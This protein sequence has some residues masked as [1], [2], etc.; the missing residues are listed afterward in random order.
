MRVLSRFRPLVVLFAVT[1]F[2]CANVSPNGEHEAGSDGVD[3]HSADSS[4]SEEPSDLSATDTPAADTVSESDRHLEVADSPPEDTE[5][6]AE[7]TDTAGDDSQISDT[8]SETEPDESLDRAPD[9][10][11]DREVAS[12]SIDRGD[13]D[14]DV[15]VGTYESEVAEDIVVEDKIAPV[16][17]VDF[18]MGA[19]LT[20]ASRITV[21]GR[22]QDPSGISSLTIG[23]V[24]A[25]SD[26][27]FATWHA[28]LELAV[29]D[30]DFLVTTSDSLGNS[31]E[32]AAAVAI[33]RRRAIPMVLD[34][35]AVDDEERFAYTTD[36]VRNVLLRGDLE[37][38]TF[39]TLNPSKPIGSV[40]GLAFARHD[41]S[42][43]LFILNM[44]ELLAVDL[45]SLE[46]VT[47]DLDS[48]GITVSQPF[49]LDVSDDGE[50]A[51][52]GWNQTSGGYSVERIELSTMTRTTIRTAAGYVS[53]L[54]TDSTGNLYLIDNDTVDARLINATPRGGFS[55]LAKY[56]DDLGPFPGTPGGIEVEYGDGAI[57]VGGNGGLVRV[58][59]SSSD[60]DVLL[61]DVEPPN[62][63]LH[64]YEAIRSFGG[65]D[66]VVEPVEAAIWRLGSDD[67]QPAVH[68]FLGS[69]PHLRLPRGLVPVESAGSEVFVGDV[70]GN[71]YRIDFN[72]GVRTVISGIG[73][74]FGR[75]FFGLESL[76]VSGTGL[77]VLDRDGL[78]LLGTEHGERVAISDENVGE[79]PAFSTPSDLLMLDE[80]NAVVLDGDRVLTVALA[81]GNRE[82]LAD[83]ASSWTVA[84]SRSEGMVFDG[85]SRLFVVAGGEV[86]AVSIDDG[87]IS[88]VSGPEIGDGPLDLNSAALVADNSTGVLYHIEM[89]GRVLAIDGSGNRTVAA[90]AEVGGGPLPIQVEQAYF[91][92][93][94]E[95]VIAASMGFNSI[96]QVDPSTGDRVILSR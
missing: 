22:A 90:D 70:A 51:H 34:H 37:S 91:D 42:A 47:F 12:D 64:R 71:V 92:R 33:D 89:W 58:D 24:E 5:S 53:G 40:R 79:G 25:A 55:I 76:A 67:V 16:V 50:V 48:P 66:Y 46:A 85:H 83:L 35:L 20:D 36:R 15:T 27:G 41:G 14:P 68:S 87:A 21:R 49:G 28:E 54:D 78:S 75:Y 61:G 88:I 94:T 31:S 81:T 6:E 80:N 26:D 9:P 96:I 62:H 10:G 95:S 52:I 59:I 30:N 13:D 29:G 93:R 72:S 38:G 17:F 3:T 74:G 73:Q 44:Y 23:D 18:P 84:R 57:L 11:G 60:R 2:S 45:D 19:A 32:R 63:I 39:E 69:G 65:G 82:Q 77:F 8:A 56:R 7:P 43:T 86:A 4:P 1:S